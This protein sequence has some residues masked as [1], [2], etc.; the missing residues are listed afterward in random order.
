MTNA[1]MSS[2]SSLSRFT[3]LPRS[4]F[5]PQR[6]ALTSSNFP[7]VPLSVYQVLCSEDASG[8]S[9]AER[10]MNMLFT[11][12]VA[13]PISNPSSFCSGFWCSPLLVPQK[14]QVRYRNGTLECTRMVERESLFKRRPFP[15]PL[16]VSDLPPDEQEKQ[17]SPTTSPPGYGTSVQ[18]PMIAPCWCTTASIAEYGSPF[19]KET[20]NR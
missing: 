15:R 11:R 2:L 13:L 8:A 5:F 16:L 4:S 3:E 14:E 10:D 6:N 12:V 20:P 9:Y 7:P 18:G 19:H 1:Y 17:V